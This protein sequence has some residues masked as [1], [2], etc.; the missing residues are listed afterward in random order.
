[1]NKSTAK[2]HPPKLRPNDH[3][4]KLRNFYRSRMKIF[5]HKINISC[6]S[7]EMYAI[8]FARGQTSRE[9]PLREYLLLSIRMNLRFGSLLVAKYIKSNLD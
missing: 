2:I 3:Y 1:M 8:S 7:Q 9:M 5:H 4:A 6:K